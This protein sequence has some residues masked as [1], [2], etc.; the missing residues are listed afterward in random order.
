MQHEVECDRK[1]AVL[2]LAR[3]TG[4]LRPRDVEAAGIPREYLLRLLREGLLVRT[5]RGL[6]SLP[7]MIA[8]E[9]ATL[10]DVAKR[11]PNGVVCLISALTFHQLTTQ[12][13][14]RVWVAIE[15]RTWEPR[16]VYPTLELVRMGS[17]SFTYGVEQHEIDRTTVRIYSPA[18]TVADCF[19]FR[20]RIGLDVALES[21]RATWRERRATMDEMWEA[22]AVCRVA[23]VMRPYLES[24]A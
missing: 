3:S 6:Y 16:L 2:Q 23:N 24:I 13:S 12:V 19:K 11:V 5:G 17:R 7:D 20:N 9:S 10:A 4:V 1:K 21:L 15:R 18:K 14:D 22:A 8:S